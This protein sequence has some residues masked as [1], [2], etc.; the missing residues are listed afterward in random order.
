QAFFNNTENGDKVLIYTQAKKAILYRPSTD[1]IIEVATLNLGNS[2]QESISA[3]P[4]NVTLYNGTKIAGL[5]KTI[6]KQLKEKITGIEVIAKDNAK[7]NYAKNFVIDVS[8]NQATKVNEIAKELNAEV[9]VLPKEEVKPQT[10]ILVIL[11]E[12]K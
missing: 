2:N 9:T 1:K 6:E 10:D 8:G 4:V 7:G 11:G 5:A 12:S 3:K